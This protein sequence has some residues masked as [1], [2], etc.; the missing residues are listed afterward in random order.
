MTRFSIEPKD[1][2][3][4]KGYGILSFAKN[5]RK[6]IGKKLSG[7]YSQKLLNHAKQS[8]KDEKLIQKEQFKKLLKQLLI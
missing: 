2:I 6:N 8:T 4:V 5:M 1:R 7:K 3:F